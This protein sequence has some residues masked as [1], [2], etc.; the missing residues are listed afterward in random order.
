MYSAPR[1]RRSPLIPPRR[2]RPAIRIITDGGP[3]PPSR[4]AVVTTLE[5]QLTWCSWFSNSLAICP[6]LAS[7]QS[8]SAE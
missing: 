5:A 3:E 6:M 2:R 1:R 7:M 4:P 8:R